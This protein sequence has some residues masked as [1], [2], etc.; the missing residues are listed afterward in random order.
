MNARTEVVFDFGRNWQ[1]FVRAGVDERKIESAR[2]SLR[3]L[4]GVSDLNGRSFLDIGCGSGLSSLAAVSLG[5]RPVIG[6]DADPGSLAASAELRASAGIDAGTW[7]LLEGSILDPSF[8]ATLGNADVVH[9][10]GSLHHTGAL[11]QAIDNACELVACEGLLVLAIYNDVDGI[12]GSAEWRRIKSWYSRAP[13]A[14]RLLMEWAYIAQRATCDLLALRNPAA[15]L[16]GEMCERGMDFRVDV[17]DWLGGLPY[18]YASALAV[19]ERV[20]GKLGFELCYLNAVQGHS[21][22]EF[23]FRRPSPR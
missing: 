5:A 6:F 12:G 13:R 15:R 2:H 1:S 20:Q 17:R 18:E 3:H 23:T 8:L 4:L 14:L 9:A 16:R 19:V 21:C 7:Q 10:W 11:W 22:N